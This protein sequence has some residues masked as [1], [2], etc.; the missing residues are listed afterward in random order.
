MMISKRK[1]LGAAVLACV[2]TPG[3]ISPKVLRAGQEPPVAKGAAARP[4]GA[5][6]AD[7]ARAAGRLADVLKR[8]PARLSPEVGF[9]SQIYM[10]DL[11]DG[12]MTLI[13]DVPLPN[14]VSNGMPVWSHGGSRILFETTGAQW[15]IARLIAIEAR[16]GRPTYTD[17]GPGNRP[18]FSPDDKRIASSIYP[19]AEEGV[20]SGVWLMNADGSGRRRVAEFGAPSWSPDG[21]ELLINSYP[22]P[23][24]STLFNLETKEGVV[25]KA[26]G[27]TIFSWPSWAGPGTLVSALRKEGEGES[28]ALL[29]VRNPAEAKVIE[30]L[31]KRG[32]ELDV[33]PRWPVY[34]PDSR[35]CLFAG[36][37][38]K[39]RSLYMVQRGEFRAIQLLVEQQRPG[40]VQH[41]SGL[42]FSPDGRYLFFTANR[43]DRK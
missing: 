43:P 35:R 40:H 7:S 17:L 19:D 12:E 22:V 36:E 18:A 10:L 1:V 21:R 26:P 25:V 9:G 32:E 4:A 42:S 16:D 6:D 38:P 31:W 8:H 5:V 41:L 23:T 3:G 33:A 14:Q 37:E 15:P 39:L 29:D 28:I 2:L 20:E 27:H 13:A 11:E 30:T 34:R 24:K